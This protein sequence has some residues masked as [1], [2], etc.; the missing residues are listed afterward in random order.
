MGYGKSNSLSIYFAT[1]N[2]GDNFCDRLFAFPVHK[3]LSRVSQ[4]FSLTL[5]A[6]ITIKE[7]TILVFFFYYYDF[8]KKRSLSISCELVF[9]EK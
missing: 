2:K 4:L 3:S 9:S 7:T 5:K 1:F 6:P 8:Q